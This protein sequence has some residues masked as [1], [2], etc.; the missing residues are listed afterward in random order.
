MMDNMTTYSLTVLLMGIICIGLGY[1]IIYPIRKIERAA[2]SITQKDFTIKLRSNRRDE[3]GSLARSINSMSSELEKT[4]NNLHLEIEHVT[5]LEDLRKEFVSNFTHEIKTPLGIINGFSELI[6]IEEDEEKR[7]EYIDIIQQE[8]RKINQLVIAMLDLSKLESKNIT[9]NISDIDIVSLCENILETMSVHI[10]NKNLIVE[11]DFH[12]CCIKG[13]YQKIEMA[14]TNLVSNA[15]RYTHDNGHIYI[16]INERGFYI[17]NEGKHISEEE[18]S[19]IWLAFHKIDKSRNDEGTGL[20]L[21]IVKAALDLHGMKYG[22]HNTS[23]GVLFY[24]EY[25]ENQLK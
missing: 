24:F 6:E 9:L 20:G 12:E 7:N 23:K 2:D 10:Q 13:D 8:T 22:V 4:I 1:F 5:Q 16:T 21:S 11:R 15:M 14:I 19:K 3:I 18:L 17:E 25:N